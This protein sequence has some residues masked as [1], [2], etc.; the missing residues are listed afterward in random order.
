M[1]SEAKEE[2]E[3]KRKRKYPC[4]CLEGEHK[5]EATESACQG[6]EVTAAR[7]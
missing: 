6:Y 7:A 1:V 3:K 4:P 5:M 2:R